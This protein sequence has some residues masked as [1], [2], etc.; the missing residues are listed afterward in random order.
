M[1]TSEIKSASFISLRDFDLGTSIWE[2]LILVKRLNE[3][4]DALVMLIKR[5]LNSTLE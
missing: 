5:K 4:Y 2:K 1:K 3:I